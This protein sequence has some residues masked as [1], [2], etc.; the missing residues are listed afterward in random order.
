ME[1]VD[2]MVIWQLPYLLDP[3]K[4]VYMSVRINHCPFHDGKGWCPI[5]A[6]ASEASTNPTGSQG[7][8]IGPQ[9]CLYLRQEG[10]TFI[11][12]PLPTSHCML[13]VSWKAREFGRSSFLSWHRFPKSNS[14]DSFQPPTT[15]T[16]GEGSGNKTSTGLFIF[17]EWGCWLIF[18]VVFPPWRNGLALNGPYSGS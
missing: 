12:T 8:K 13:A 11:F 4:C 9:G 5:T 17:C 3:L 10:F 7:A 1:P 16:D 15:P 18:A 2:P 14:A 6:V